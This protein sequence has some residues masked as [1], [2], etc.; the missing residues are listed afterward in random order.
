MLRIPGWLAFVLFVPLQV[1]LAVR[2][3]LAYG[4]WIA[5]LILVILAFLASRAASVHWFRALLFPNWALRREQRR[6]VYQGILF[7]AAAFSLLLAA[8][9]QRWMPAGVTAWLERGYPW[10]PLACVVWLV[11]AALR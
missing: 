10:L 4:F 2:L 3:F 7:L 11:K 9:P 8:S 6:H 5:L 1:F